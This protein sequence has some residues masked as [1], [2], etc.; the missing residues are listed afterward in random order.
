VKAQKLSD[1]ILCFQNQNFLGPNDPILD[2]QGGLYF[3]A[4]W[5]NPGLV[6]TFSQAFVGG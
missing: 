5:G 3:T 1:Y 6:A 4:P 2:R